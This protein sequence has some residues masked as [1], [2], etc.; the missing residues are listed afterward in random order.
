VQ[1]DRPPQRIQ[2]SRAKGWRMPESASYVGRPGMWGN[3][4]SGPTR[5]IAARMFRCWLTGSVRGPS[6]LEC[7]QV[8]PGDLAARRASVLRH[9]GLLHG[10]DLACWCR[11]DQPCHADVLLELANPGLRCEAATN[12]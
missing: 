9:I 5:E 10:I 12:G 6:S 3:P 8:V 11:L 2:R 1:P 4:F 7:R